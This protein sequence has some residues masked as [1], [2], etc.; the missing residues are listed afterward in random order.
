MYNFT[1]KMMLDEFGFLQLVLKNV[2]LHFLLIVRNHRETLFIP[3]S[4]ISNFAMKCCSEII[5]F[6]IML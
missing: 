6:V 2:V 5:F 4:S 1:L 3:K